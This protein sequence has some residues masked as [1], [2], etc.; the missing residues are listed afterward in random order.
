MHQLPLPQHPER[1]DEREGMILSAELRI[2]H[3][4]ESRNTGGFTHQDA[5]S[6][7]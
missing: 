2:S 7:K 3:R 6:E 5:E 1:E 4:Q